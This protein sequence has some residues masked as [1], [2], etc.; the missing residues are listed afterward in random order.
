MS[1]GRKLAI[2]MLATLLALPL[3]GCEEEG[4]AENFGEKV[5]DTADDAGDSM[6]KMGDKMEDAAD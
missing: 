4:P 2:P 6:E 5:D 1:I 3:V